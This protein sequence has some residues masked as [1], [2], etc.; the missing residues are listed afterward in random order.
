[1]NKINF[2][3]IQQTYTQA[4]KANETALISCRALNESLFKNV[5]FLKHAE[6]AIEGTRPL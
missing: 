1:M 3:T 6:T 2:F 5:G 4:R